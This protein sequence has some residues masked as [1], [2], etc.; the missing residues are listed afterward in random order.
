ML[1]LCN[2]DEGLDVNWARINIDMDTPQVL[3]SSLYVLITYVTGNVFPSHIIERFFSPYT[4]V[5]KHA[6]S[7]I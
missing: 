4:L 5:K 2:Y 1:W 3:R 7:L 6:A